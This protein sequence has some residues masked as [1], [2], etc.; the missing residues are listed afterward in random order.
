MNSIIKR[1]KNSRFIHN[2]G[3]I[4][5]AQIYQMLISLV[6]G[7][8]TARYLGATNYGTINYAASYVSFFTIACQLGLEGIV[9]KEIINHRENE[10]IILGSSIV[11]RLKAGMLSVIAVCMII[12]LVNPNDRTLVIVAFLQS[13]VLIFNAFNIIECWYQ[14]NLQSKT[15]TIIRC[16]AYTVMSCYKIVLLI[17]G[18]SLV[19]FAF[20]TSF[21]SLIIAILFVWHYKNN[22]KHKLKYATNVAKNLFSQS[23]H[24]IISSLMAVVYSQMDKIMIGKMINQTH[25]GYYSAASTICNMWM[26]IPQA[27]TNSARPL[28]VQL[29]SKDEALY[30]KRLKQLNFVTFWLGVGFAI[31][32]TLLANFIIYVL[33]GAGYSEAEGPLMLIIWSTV[34]SAMSYP[35]SIWMICEGNQNYTKHILIWGVIVNL[36]LNSLLIP[37]IGMNG[38]AFATIVTEFMCCMIAPLFYKSTRIYVRYLLESIVGIG[39]K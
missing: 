24:L 39:I 21:D 3:W 27:M 28:I 37:V 26:F 34:F 12:W 18:K 14:S 38:A 31:I 20:S 16:I 10:G 5:F 19:W 8:I 17:T 30:I 15:S 13:L 29:K 23:Y 35:R 11:M 22:C 7:V 32:I 33:Y 4:M 6:I 2:T 1:L 25:V 9:V 36:T